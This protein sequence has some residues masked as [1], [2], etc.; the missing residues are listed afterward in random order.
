[1]NPVI[2]WMNAT[3]SAP[4]TTPFNFGVI[5]ADDVS[6][7][8][9]FNIWNNRFDGAGGGTTDVSKME[10]CTITTRDMSGGLGNTVG[11]EIEVVKNNWFHAQV[12]SLGETDLAQESSR[13]GKDYTKPIGTTGTTKKDN[14]GATYATPLKPGTKEILGVKNNGVPADAAGN[15]VTVT[16]QADVPLEAKSGQQAFKIRVSYRYV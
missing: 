13:I 6:T 3:H 1:M 16:L 15:Y 12:D 10:D 4:V 2:T 11:S 5:D 8:Y 9:T 7:P 14:T